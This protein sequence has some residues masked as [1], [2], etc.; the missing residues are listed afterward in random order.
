MA[1]PI[2]GLKPIKLS[3][4][5]TST[6]RP[7]GSAT[8]QSL[9]GH[10]RTAAPPPPWGIIPTCARPAPG[11]RSELDGARRTALHHYGTLLQLDTRLTL[12]SSGGAVLNLKGE[13]IGITTALAALTGVETPGG[14]AVPLDAGLRIG[15]S[16]EARQGSRV[17]FP[18]RQPPARTWQLEGGHHRRASGV[19]G[20]PGQACNPGTALTIN[21]GPVHDVTT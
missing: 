18:R 5:R 7:D 20:L 6:Q 21:G 9:C 8:G 3:R 1:D 14:F 17:R 11:R 4:P 16:A 13:L 10:F 12:G 19:A 2:P 15:G